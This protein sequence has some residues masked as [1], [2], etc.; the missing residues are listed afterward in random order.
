MNDGI[1]ATADDFA[2]GLINNWIMLLV[3]TEYAGWI[4]SIAFK[5]DHCPIVPLPI[6][7]IAW[8]CSVKMLKARAYVL[9]VHFA[10]QDGSMTRQN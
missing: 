4:V 9:V 7:L 8:V 2:G 3:E 10:L 1:D 5:V 6:S